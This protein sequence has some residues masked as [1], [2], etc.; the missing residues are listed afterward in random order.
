[1]NKIISNYKNIINEIKSYEK[2]FYESVKNIDLVAVS[3]TFPAEKIE[4]ILNLGHRVFG[5]NRVQ[6]A[7]EK[8]PIL[9]K[10]FDNVELHLIGPLQ[11]NKAKTALEIFDVIQTL[12]REKIV[13]KI[14]EFKENDEQK[15]VHKFFIQVNTGNEQQKAGIEPDKLIDFVSWCKNDVNLEI[16]GLMCIPPINEPSAKHFKILSSLAKKSS[17]RFL[18][19]GMSNDFKEAIEFGATHVRVGSGIFGKR[20]Q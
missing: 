18:S 20:D 3:K 7:A 14:K 4:L 5:E 11:S 6:E 2:E 17:L 1:M 19:M 8:W 16:S 9:K 12:D 10:N 15:K 13:L